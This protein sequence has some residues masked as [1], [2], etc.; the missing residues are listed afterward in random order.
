M[1][2]HWLQHASHEDL[3]CI[4]PWLARRGDRVTMT[5]LWAGD[6]PPAAP[7]FDALIVMGGPMNIY[8]HDAHPWLVPEKRLIRAAIDAGRPA[9]GICLGSQLIADVMGAPVTRNAHTEIG[10]F[11]VSLNPAGRALALFADWPDTFSAFHWHGDTFAIPPGAQNLMSS[12][13]C[14]HQGYTIGDRVIGL[15]FHLEVTAADARVWLAQEE[16][17]P[18]TYVQA[19]D[20]ILG[21]LDRFALNNRLMIKLLDRW[22]PNP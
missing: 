3:G 14:A 11:D 17:K 19:P 21:E 6:P 16:L 15:Q 20:F 4:G 9:L 18:S 2:V 10:W 22:L 5:R 7:D 8:E 1:H 12:A 13:G